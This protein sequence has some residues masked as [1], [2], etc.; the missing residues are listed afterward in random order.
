M[1]NCLLKLKIISILLIIFISNISY[2]RNFDGTNYCDKAN[3]KISISLIIPSHFSKKEQ[4]SLYNAVQDIN[5]N[6]IKPGDLVQ[7]SL[8]KKNNTEVVF[9]NC[10][11]GC[12]P[13]TAIQEIFGVGDKCNLTRM[14]KHSKEYKFIML[15]KP[16]KKMSIDAKKSKNVLNEGII[17]IMQALDNYAQFND[18][19]DFD[20]SYIVS[21]MNPLG[22]KNTN[23]E[24]DKINEFFIKIVENNKIPKK[25]PDVIFKGVIQNSNILNFW[26]DIYQTKKM[27]FLYE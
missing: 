12:P 11:P 20:K 7:Y 10:K 2:A 27:K 13:K 15:N 3:K 25:L 9:R 14:K 26:Q 17:D 4:K 21:S 5:N 22:S 6:Q 16:F 24:N 18:S 8:I 23:I 1:I 19:K